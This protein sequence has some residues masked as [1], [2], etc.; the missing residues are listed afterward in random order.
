MVIIQEQF[1]SSVHTFDNDTFCTEKKDFHLQVVAA[2]LGEHMN[3][4][5]ELFLFSYELI[6]KVL[7]FLMDY[8]LII[9]DNVTRSEKY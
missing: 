4:F 9:F 1:L 2:F 6:L 8:H 7:Q 5:D 3:F